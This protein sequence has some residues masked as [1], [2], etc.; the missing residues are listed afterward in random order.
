MVRRR[1]VISFRLT[2]E[3]CTELANGI[4]DANSLD[5]SGSLVFSLLYATL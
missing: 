3:L 2:H 1:E 5:E 4:E